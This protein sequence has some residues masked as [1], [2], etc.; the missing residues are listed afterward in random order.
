MKGIYY[1]LLFV[2]IITLS[3][4][5]AQ[6]QLFLRDGK[7]ISCKIVALSE[8][9]I[10][11]R[12]TT[13]SMSLIT[14]SKQKVLMAE[15]KTGSVYTFSSFNEG[16]STPINNQKP[17]KK[18]I[19]EDELMPTSI[20]ASNIPALF[21]GRFTLSYEHLFY[22]KTIGVKVPLIITSNFILKKSNDRLNY[23]FI[24]GIDINF[25][26]EVEVDLPY[27]DDLKYFIG[28]RIRYGT[29]AALDGIE[30]FTFQIQNGFL[31]CSEDTKLVNSLAFG[32]GF[33]KSSSYNTSLGAY[34]AEK[35]YP[36]A[37][38][39]WSIGIGW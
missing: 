35:I 4:L 39:T 2:F 5:N 19:S 21:V 13:E 26:N 30:G 9:T 36:W 10:S 11:Y 32:L 8:R 33:F 24:S 34:E 27:F 29:E 37:S 25:Y 1:I 17:L 20:V 3:K 22:N 31:L 18:A 6:D 23:G 28:P 15:Y 14:I 16:N 7:I 12:D 38:I